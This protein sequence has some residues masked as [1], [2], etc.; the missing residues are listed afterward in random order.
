M[1]RSTE[2]RMLG[3]TA[4]V[5]VLALASNLALFWREVVTAATFGVGAALDAFIVA[6]LLPVF[7][8]GLLSGALAPALAPALAA[9]R[10][11][12]GLESA[13]Q[14]LANFHLW[15]VAGS[16]AL[17]LAL[18][19]M[20]DLVP[21][22]LGR[23]LD[24]SARAGIVGLYA[25][26]LPLVVLQTS[27][28]V[29]RLALNMD[30]RVVLAAL[31][32][33]IAP[34]SSVALMLADRAAGGVEVL[35]WGLL[36]GTVAEWTLLAVAAH[37]THCWTRRA[38]AVPPV[39]GVFRSYATLLGAAAFTTSAWLIDNAMASTLAA[40]S[41]A[42]LGFGG[43]V[44]TFA[45]GIVTI[46]L[47]T[48]LLPVAVDLVARRQWQALHRLA[49][50]YG[51]ILFALCL[52]VALAVFAWS[53]DLT[54]ILYQRGAFDAADTMLVGSVQAALVL[55]APFHVVGVLCVRLLA[56]LQLNR[57]VLI[58]AA[59]GT[60][61]N[62]VLNLLLMTRWGVVGI[63]AATSVMFVVTALSAGTVLLGELA[64]RIE[65]ERPM[66]IA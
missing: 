60:G 12:A 62:V 13:R 66:D 15:A 4:L 27:A 5:S 26:L 9:R 49:I 18:W 25:L 10:H 19:S 28:A 16:G 17:A 20:A 48:A 58:I 24:D 42:A 38:W 37:R 53:T 14:M 32:P 1:P 55:Q 11:A 41:V 59:A 29:W 51:G 39:P 50:R 33:A 6:S 54:A 45:I 44:V 7:A 56:A 34:L 36:G 57:H 61:V 65:E 35:A 52:P 40:G 63:A 3:A 22:L 47:S 23:A 30:H 31:T 43:K 46:G 64:R 8:A 2:A 21:G